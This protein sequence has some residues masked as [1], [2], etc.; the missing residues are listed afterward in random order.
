[1]PRQQAPMNCSLRR[2]RCS[3]PRLGRRAE[4]G[5]SSSSGSVLWSAGCGGPRH[6]YRG[7]ASCSSAAQRTQPFD[8][9]EESRQPSAEGHQS[10]DDASSSAHDLR[11]DADHRV[12]EG[13]KLHAKQR[14][15][16]GVV[17]VAPTALRARRRMRAGGGGAAGRRTLTTRRGPTIAGDGVHLIGPVLPR[18]TRAVLVEAL[19]VRAPSEVEA[20]A[21]NPMTDSMTIGG[22]IRPDSP[23]CPGNERPPETV[24]NARVRRVLSGEGDGNRT[25]N[26]RIDSPVL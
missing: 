8:A 20:G 2:R 18:R 23:S 7:V 10:E 13:A 11:G 14:L 26:H 6:P 5:W 16:F 9:A 15:L 21:E 12:Q 17:A 22:D 25:R 1:M 24:R 19:N 3:R 4:P